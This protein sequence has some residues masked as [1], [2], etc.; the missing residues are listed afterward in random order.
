MVKTVRGDSI[1]ILPLVFSLLE[2]KFGE[3]SG[4]KESTIREKA[5]QSLDRMWEKLHQHR[6]KVIRLYPNKQKH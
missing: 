2:E 4:Q 6:L 5:T 3:V 1:D